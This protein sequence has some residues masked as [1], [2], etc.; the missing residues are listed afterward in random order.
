M[1][2]SPEK[3]RFYPIFFFLSSYPR[4]SVFTVAA[5]F[6]SG[7]A[8]AVSFAAIIP[9]LGLALVPDSPEKEL[10]LLEGGIA[11]V[12][13]LA[14][15]EMT[16]GSILALVVVL[17]ALKSCL[18]FYAMKE[19]GYIC[20]DVELDFRKRMVNSLLYAD[21]SYYLGNQTGDFST[22]ISTQVQGAAN[23][24]RA[25]GLVLAGLI[26]VG[27]FSVMSLTI[28]FA[29]TVAGV[30]LGATVMFALRHFVTLARVSAATL[31]KH[32]GTLLST[33]IDGLRGIKSNKAMGMQGRL[34]DYL[35]QDIE[36]LAA[37]RKR[38][39]LSSSVLKNFQEPVQVL[40]IAAALFFLTSYWEGAVE[41]LLVL[42]L[43]FYRT[44][45]RLGNLQIYYQQIQSAFPPFWFVFKI[46]SE[47][48]NA[49]EDIYSGLEATYEKSIIFENV[50]FSYGD[51]RV[52][53]QVDLKINAGE[54]VTV[55]GASGGGKTTLTDMLLGFNVPDAGSIKIDDRNINSLSR[56]SL[57][58][59]IGYV[60]QET[61]LFYDTV[62]NN[63]TFG[64]P[65]ITET[66][67]RE[68]LTRAGAIEFVDKLPGE[69]DFVVGEHG[70]R[71]SGGQKQRLGLTR[72][73]LHSPQILLL[74]EPT[75]ALDKISEK[76]IIN[77][78]NSLKGTVSII[79][80]S[81]QKTFVDASDK[82]YLLEGGILRP[83]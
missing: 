81:H 14:N 8:E 49:R 75:S 46:I 34:Q 30:L 5:L 69:L 42:I 77:T 60:P 67:L 80:I 3:N 70:G 6:L 56:S 63:L 83:E 68:A 19:V 82:K 39:V 10:G 66:S 65:K 54:F 44:G 22:A 73:L 33:L 61:V 12:F 21:W 43:L 47:A 50:S 31:T 62:R 38:L 76:A 58:K 23:V 1:S 53:K 35:N 7:L 15:L 20:A 17:M 4:R 16:V 48:E 55:I 52:L 27:L 9:L 11:Q 36:Q 24:F 72:A 45:Q 74:D 26:Q 18:S 32:E 29:I 79:A 41:E 64:D 57:R 25:T 51:N 78:L 37:M 2:Y 71:L 40:G 59:L 13:D 28:S